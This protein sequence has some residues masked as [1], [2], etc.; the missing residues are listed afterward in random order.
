MLNIVQKSGTIKNV[1]RNEQYSIDE[2]LTIKSQEV[3]QRKYK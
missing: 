1:K 2:R 3:K